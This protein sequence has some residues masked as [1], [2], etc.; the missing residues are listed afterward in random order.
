MIVL[1]EFCELVWTTIA[2]V[3]G[4]TPPRIGGKWPPLGAVEGTVRL[5]EGSS[6]LALPECRCPH[7]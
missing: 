7:L 4:D 5:P 3:G 6:P 1:A 2:H